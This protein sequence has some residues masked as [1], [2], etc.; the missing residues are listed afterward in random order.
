M[1]QG[2]TSNIMNIQ[3]SM[4]HEEDIFQPEE[5]TLIVTNRNDNNMMIEIYLKQYNTIFCFKYF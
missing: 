3:S 2:K 4:L 5:T 1:K